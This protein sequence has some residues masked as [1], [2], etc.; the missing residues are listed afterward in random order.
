MK[1]RIPWILVVLAAVAGLW[2]LLATRPGPDSAG[3]DDAPGAEATPQLDRLAIVERKRKAREDGG[4]DLSPARALGRVTDA[5]GGAGIG[6][7]IV[8]LTPKGLDQHAR[9]S[10]S[11]ESARPLQA[12]TAADG[13]WTIAP[14][15][16]GRYALSATA[17]GYL[18]TTRTDVTLVAGQDDPGLDLQLGRGGHEVRGTVSDI[19]GGPVEDVLVRVT[20]TDDSPFNFD[21]PALGVVTDEEGAFGL[22][23]SDGH[24]AV[25]T[26][27]PDYVDASETLRV[28]GGP[29]ALA[30]TITPA[31]SIEGR[32]LARATG[33]PIEGAI[34]SRSG[35]ETGGFTVQGLGQDP[36]V[37]DAEGRFRL[38]GLPSGVVR[39]HAAA[40][41]FATRQA[42]EVVLG[43]AE[44]VG[45]VE[46]LVDEALTIS[47]FVV[48]RG[49]EERGLQGVLVGAFSID[50]G[51]LYVASAPSAADGYFEI[52][53]V[54]PGGYTVG[55]IGE[56]ALPNMLGASA[57]V[58][59][60]DVTDVLVVMDAGV[61]LRGR[62]APGVPAKISLRVDGEG[63]SIGTMMQSMSNML[64]RAR[65]DEQ[66]AFDLH[67]VAEGAITVVAEADD[68]SRGELA[69]QVGEGDVD[70]L[71]IEL[72]P[73]A[74]VAGRVVDA[75]GGPGSGLEV[76]LVAKGGQG[77]GGLS[78]GLGG[79]PRG[80]HG[81]TTDDDGIFEVTGLD[82]GEYELSVSAGRG[83]TLEWAEPADPEAPRQPIAIT[84]A[85]GERRQ[86][87]LLA[88]EA[89]DGVITGVVLGADGEPV[90]D[91]WVTAVRNDSARE[92]MAEVTRQRGT[93]PGQD[94]DDPDAEARER[95]LR[96][97]ELMGLSEPPVLTD[98]TG[99]F[100]VRG[101]R[102]GTYRLRAEA[103]KDGARGFVD[104]VAL[105]ADVSVRL[106]ALAGLEGVVRHR[107]KP[108]AEYTVSI[109]GRSS[110]QQQVYSPDGRFFVGRID[111]GQYEVIARS[112]HGVA[113]AEVEI[114]EGGTHSVA[115]EI[116]G[117]GT[118][119]GIV[120]DAGTGD[121]IPG[122]AI[123]VMG[124]GGVSASS[125][126]SVFTGVGPKTD[127]DGRFSVGEVPPG[128]GRIV[129]LDRDA[130]GMGGQVAEAEYVVEADGEQD[131]GTITGVAPSY[132]SPDERG[133]LGLQVQVATY[134]KRPRPP[135]AEDD[136]EQA[137]FDL[138][139]RLWVSHVTPNGP[140]A[141]AGLV[142]GDE[143]IAVDGSG[144]VGMGAGNAAK[145]LSPRHVRV[146][147]A[148][149]LEIEHDGNRNRVT[150][151][152]GPQPRAAGSG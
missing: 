31:G 66:G 131:L 52:F 49:D 41:G 81:A 53:G 90:V 94:D 98:Q 83:P 104:E 37:T 40:R 32:V 152:A 146:G 67:P 142:P 130:T 148:V 124:D 62:V 69:V 115:L 5:E 36:V 64:V 43:V 135:G 63:M 97:W 120:V 100:A 4:I 26:F 54:L 46:L 74:S 109:D 80:R 96:Q 136:Q 45:G 42:V 14:A 17:P 8:L 122:L 18:P 121:P 103:H 1:Q 144:V 123:T 99:R 93:D 102:S 51:R 137:A 21:R 73:R 86:G 57:Q 140:A 60:Q 91:A 68:G 27:H 110:R 30:L 19:G 34:V 7:A 72:R 59:D 147:D 25:S 48:A 55:A 119:R 129:F 47:G 95:G 50:P 84:V 13:S 20:R 76:A 15:P 44:Q 12:R 82:A 6:G 88:V 24:Y 105:G 87:L 141:L 151:T 89:R 143:V 2:W 113:K 58:R 33:Q 39:L 65:S 22:Q 125:V 106:E 127:D 133:S 92:W 11:G 145:L 35:E 16:A 111:A 10:T 70:G 107:G 138:T 3:D 128:E 101:L 85:E 23:L 77:G 112:Q 114:A 132:I 28:D 79:M 108:V 71:V 117:W 29:R 9:A 78:M 134:G 75:H 61:H 126:M 139:K 150:L 38:R 149:A 116:G 56:D 118:L